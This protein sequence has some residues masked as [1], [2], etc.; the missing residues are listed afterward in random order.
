M[1]RQVGIGAAAV[2]SIGLLAAG[3]SEDGDTIV[4]GGGG[5]LLPG[6]TDQ[7]PFAGFE[8]NNLSPDGGAFSENGASVDQVLVKWNCDCPDS[9]GDSSNADNTALVLFTMFDNGTGNVNTKRALFASH[10]ENGTFT[11]PVELL[12]DDR[13]Q[14]VAIELDSY[15]LIPM[16]TASYQSGSTST[17]TEINTVRDNSGNWLILGEYT[18]QFQTPGLDTTG[19]ASLTSNNRGVRRTIA[20]WVFQKNLRSSSL[21]SNAL[22]GGVTQPF[23]YGFQELGT[24]I[25]TTFIAGAVNGAAVNGTSTANLDIPACHVTSYGAV[26]DGFCGETCFDGEALPFVAESNAGVANQDFDGFAA[27]GANALTNAQRTAFTHCFPTLSRTGNNADIFARANRTQLVQLGTAVYRP[28][29]E[30]SHIVA[31]WTQVCSSIAGG[32][33]ISSNQADT[34]LGG[35]ELQLRYR[36]FNLASQT[37]EADETEVAFAAERNAR[38]GELRAGTQ[39]FPVLRGYN[40]NLFFKYADASLIVSTGNNTGNLADQNQLA[41]YPNTNGNNIN[42]WSQDDT[43][44][45][46][47]G[48]LKRTGAGNVNAFWREVIGMVRFQDDGDGTSSQAGTSLDVSSTAET[49]GSVGVHATTTVTVSNTTRDTVPSREIANFNCCD[50]DFRNRS[51]LGADEGMSDLSLFYVMADNTRT[52]T[53]ATLNMDRELW[54]VAMNPTGDL[55]TSSFAAGTNPSR[56]SGTHAADY[57]VSTAPNDGAANSPADGRILQD[58]VLIRNNGSSFAENGNASALTEAS[59]GSNY[60]ASGA[61]PCYFELCLNRTGSY[62]GILFS[63][64]SGNSSRSGAGTGF[65]QSLYATVYQP[66]RPAVSTTSS[67]TSTLTAANLESRLPSAGPTRVDSDTGFGITQVTLNQADPAN[68]AETSR[69]WRALPVNAYG[70]QGYLGYRVGFQS[71]INVMT[72]FW[73]QSDSTEDRV[74]FRRMTVTAGTGNPLSAPTLA[75]GTA[76]EIDSTASVQSFAQYL[77]DTTSRDTFTFLDGTARIWTNFKSV[78]AGANN[79]GTNGDVL[80]VYTKASDNTNSDGDGAE[81][82]IRA[83]IATASAGTSQVIDTMVNENNSTILEGRTPSLRR[84]ASANAAAST[85]RYNINSVDSNTVCHEI[86]PVPCATDTSTN[87]GNHP[88]LTTQYGVL[89]LIGDQEVV[90]TTNSSSTTTITGN[91]TFRAALYSRFYDASDN[92]NNTTLE[93]RISGIASTGYTQPPQIDHEQGVADDTKS[94]TSCKNGRTIGLVF[95]TNAQLWYQSTSDGTSFN[96]DATT[97]LS[98]PLLITNQSSQDVTAWDLDCCLDSNGDAQGVI[99]WFRKNDVDSDDRLFI[100][101]GSIQ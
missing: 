95:E 72:V 61:G 3:C 86:I 37:W 58:P 59:S 34:T 69:A 97:G 53:G 87:S 15:V 25:P 65:T 85:N 1:F 6:N 43:G 88:V 89:I 27:T 62:A 21:A 92:G 46:A 44:G 49:R 47:G 73:E 40:Q 19:G 96:R 82:E 9:D 75:L 68:D 30:V 77:D 4:T 31:V 94:P 18:T 32:G 83:L 26:T 52:G 81:Q 91:G 10:Y 93:S 100:G 56:V 70:W 2:L 39:P 71:D 35:H 78:D 76:V 64:D 84:D 41:L 36:T 66:F 98:N 17:A 7:S 24:I 55:A 28:G 42:D 50:S 99:L 11:P 14:T 45:H 74:L 29:E 79:T 51:I 60:N 90:T 101:A 13:D 12:G 22:V 5:S 57:H 80:V 8:S 48:N 33:S 16:N 23:R 54:V 38:T 63:K 67:G 20:S